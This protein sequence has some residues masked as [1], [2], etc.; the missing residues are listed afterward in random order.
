LDDNVLSSLFFLD[1]E[2][3]LS[4]I[5]RVCVFAFNNSWRWLG[6]G[7]SVRYVKKTCSF[8]S[9]TRPEIPEN[10]AKLKKKL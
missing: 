2:V 6:E 10:L 1:P 7:K 8:S 5:M 4:I 3:I 9:P